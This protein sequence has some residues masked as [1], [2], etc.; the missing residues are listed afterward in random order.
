MD[1]KE[2]KYKI[3]KGTL[4][5]SFMV[6][7]ATEDNIVVDQYIKAIK[8]SKHLETKYIDNSDSIINNLT[9]NSSKSIEKYLKR[10]NRI[11]MDNNNSNKII[12]NSQRYMNFG[13]RATNTVS[14]YSVCN[15]KFYP[16]NPNNYYA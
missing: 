12:N 7:V 8:E 3:E 4:D 9:F 5:D 10:Q 16:N 6:W 2:L 11:Y 13:Y 14:G 1:I 15:E